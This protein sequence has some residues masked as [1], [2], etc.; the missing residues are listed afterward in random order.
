VVGRAALS[1]RQHVEQRHVVRYQ[2]CGVHECLEVAAERR[3][4]RTRDEP[5][6]QFER[7]PR[8]ADR[9]DDEERTLPVRLAVRQAVGLVETRQ[10][11]E[12]E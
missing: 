9:L 6:D 12:T 1:R 11:L 7:E 8:V 10:C 4:G 5:D 3:L 2:R